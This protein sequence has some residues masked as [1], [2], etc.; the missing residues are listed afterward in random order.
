MQE[1][2]GIPC[3]QPGDAHNA[4]AK[5]VVARLQGLSRG[6]TAPRLHALPSLN[7]GGGTH[8]VPLQYVDQE[9]KYGLCHLINRGIIPLHSDLTNVLTGPDNVLHTE[10]VAL[11]PHKARFAS[12]AMAHAVSAMQLVHRCAFQY[13]WAA[14]TEQQL[15]GCS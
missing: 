14:S 11:R 6:L 4:D 1:R 15:W 8:P 9:I 7:R 12:F 3:S 5:R 2:F 10:Q 13:L